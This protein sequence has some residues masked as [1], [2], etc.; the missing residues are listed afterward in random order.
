MKYSYL[1]LG[2]GG[3]PV[4]ARGE[5]ERVVRIVSGALHA[6]GRF[7]YLGCGPE[8]RDPFILLKRDVN[9]ATKVFTTLKRGDV[10]AIGG[11]TPKNDGARLGPDSRVR[12]LRRAAHGGSD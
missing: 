5:G 2:R 9:R 12:V 3:P 6:K 11:L 10:V 1:V 7:R 4:D 8:G